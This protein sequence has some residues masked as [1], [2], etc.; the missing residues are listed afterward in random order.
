[1][2]FPFCALSII[3]MM[4]GLMM[5]GMAFAQTPAGQSGYFPAA[6]EI[7]VS[8]QISDFGFEGPEGLTETRESK[9]IAD[10]GFVRYDCRDYSNLD[11]SMKI[12]IFTLLDSHAAWSLLTLLRNNSVKDGPPGEAFVVDDNTLLFAQ[13]R[14]FVRI[15]GIGI[16]EELLIKSSAA[17]SSRIDRPGGKK[18]SSIA[19]LPQNGYDASSLRYFPSAASYDTWTKGEK[20][21]YVDTSYDMEIAQARYRIDNQTGIITLMRFPTPELSEDYF[22]GLAVTS[23]SVT[24]GLSIYARHTGPLIAILEGNFNSQS[25]DELLASVKFGYLVRWDKGDLDKIIWGVPTNI[26][27]AVV[28]S[29]IFSAIAGIGAILLGIAIGA[30]RFAVRGYRARRYPQLVEDDPDFTRL[31]LR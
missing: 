20:P 6:D 8:L 7:D 9:L 3:L 17:V 1:M 18:P 24:E 4:V 28:N 31:R 29:L 16:A 10:V 11:T 15:R 22:D 25:A 26:L 13:E 5:V 30:G 14:F 2:K 12:E 23:S 27:G 19:H 21:T